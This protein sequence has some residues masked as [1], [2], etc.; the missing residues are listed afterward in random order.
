[1]TRP[2]YSLSV[3][4]KRDARS[5]GLLKLD[6]QGRERRTYTLADIEVRTRE[7][8]AG[9]AIGFKGHAAVFGQTALI[10]GWFSEWTEK[11]SRCAFKKTIKEADVRFLINHDP[12]LVL[13]RNKAGTLRLAEDDVGLDTDADMAPTSYG[14]D[15]AIS[16]ERGDVTQMSYAFEVVKET[17]DWDADPPA[18]TIEEVRLWDVSVVTY[19]AFTE[20]DASL[21]SAGFQTLCQ[22]MGLDKRGQ[23]E[24]LHQLVAGRRD[25]PASSFATGR[26][27]EA[28]E[29]RRESPDRSTDRCRCDHRW[30]CPVGT[31]VMTLSQVG[32]CG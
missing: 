20:T 12:N 7:E 4:T 23:E 21:R 3:K 9:G 19:P 10:T 15:M 16:L 29:H 6:G 31:A 17:W 24:F 2:A 27:E 18:R 8:D 5:E 25:D 32:G 11:V 14:Q 26:S 22:S 30:D 28:G 1:V 13:G